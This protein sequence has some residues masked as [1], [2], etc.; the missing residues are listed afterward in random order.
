MFRGVAGAAAERC[1]STDGSVQLVQTLR[2]PIVPAVP[3][4]ETADLCARHVRTPVPT[5]GGGGGAR[6][7]GSGEIIKPRTMMV[8]V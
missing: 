8:N 3:G 5:G 4:T 1:G 6:R 2:R 7:R